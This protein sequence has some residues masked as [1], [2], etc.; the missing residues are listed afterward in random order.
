MKP[1]LKIIAP[2]A[3]GVACLF[4]RPTGSATQVKPPTEEDQKHYVWLTGKLDEVNS[5][6]VGMTRADL[7]KV[8]T[9]DAG[10][11]QDRYVLRSCHLIKVDVV[12]DVPK[13][14]PFAN[15]PPDTDLKIK[16]ISKP[17]LEPMYMD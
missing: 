15:R 4:M 3:L 10:L 9:Q 13:G 11:L 6:R 16:L 7:L 8:F 5:I 14:M 17:Y 2:I 1:R 12:F